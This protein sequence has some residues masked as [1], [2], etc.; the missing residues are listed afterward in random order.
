MNSYLGNSGIH[1]PVIYNGKHDHREAINS[2]MPDQNKRHDNIIKM[3]Q[4]NKHNFDVIKTNDPVVVK[5]G[6]NEEDRKLEYTKIYHEM[7]KDINMKSRQPIG[8]I[9]KPKGKV[10]EMVREWY[11]EETVN[12]KDTSGNSCTINMTAGDDSPPTATTH[13]EPD[14]P[15]MKGTCAAMQTTTTDEV[16]PNCED[17]SGNS[18]TTD[19]LLTAKNNIKPYLPFMKGTL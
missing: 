4:Q 16:T 2:A 18:C 8:V 12:V 13:I 7:S 3:M 11:I 17:K 5:G 10:I 6:L 15:V 14:P 1:H 9:N 19:Y